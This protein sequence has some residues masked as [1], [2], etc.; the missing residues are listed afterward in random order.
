LK[1]GTLSDDEIR[2]MELPYS[3]EIVRASIICCGGT[4]LAGR[5]ALE[6]GIGIHLGGGFHHAF[7]DHG[8]GFCVLNDIAVAIRVLKREGLVRRAIVVDCDLHQGNGTASIFAKDPDT[9]TFS[10]HQEDTYPFIKPASS[11]DIGLPD[12][13]GDE[14]YLGAL[15]KALSRSIPAFKPDFLLYVAGADPYR[16]DRLGGLSLSKEGLRVRDELVFGLAAGAGIPVAVVLAGGYAFR[17]EDTVGIHCNT[18]AAAL[19]A[20]REDKHAGRAGATGRRRHV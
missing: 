16:D 20:M 5:I 17:V 18:V 19:R 11:L 12:G 1:E 10:I 9:F 4:I 8:E 14:E 15:S 3:A 2:I 7:A 13:A 6:D